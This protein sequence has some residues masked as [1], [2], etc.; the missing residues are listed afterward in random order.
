M[1]ARVGI[2]RRQR[3][4]GIGVYDDLGESRAVIVVR[5]R[6]VMAYLVIGVPVMA[7]FGGIGGEGDCGCD[8]RQTRKSKP[9]NDAR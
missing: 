2:G 5:F 8:R 4:A 9:A 6:V 1:A 7:R 3:R